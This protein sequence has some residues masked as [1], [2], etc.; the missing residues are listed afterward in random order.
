MVH[1]AALQYRHNAVLNRLATAV[2]GR[3]RRG[4]TAVPDI[5][6]NQ[7]VIGDSS[8]LRPDLVITDEAAKAVTIVDV[9]IPFENRRIALDNARQL[10]R[11]KYADVARGLAARG[12][13]VTVD[14]LVV[15]SLGAW[16]RQN[17]A[18]LRHLGIA[19]RYCQLMRR[20][21]VSDT[22]KWSRDIY[23]EHITGHRQYVSP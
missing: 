5:R 18:V 3:P 1:S 14:A 10:K 8:G 21:M 23:V 22:I 6:I 4:N 9:T 7:A 13:S 2:A 17:D 11:I 15:G 20:L 19:S 16:D 12:Y